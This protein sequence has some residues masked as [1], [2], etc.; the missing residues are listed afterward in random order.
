MQISSNKIRVDIGCFVTS[1]KVMSTQQKHAQSRS[2]LNG[3]SYLGP[4][5]D[6][7]WHILTYFRNRGKSPEAIVF[8][9]EITFILTRHTFEDSD[10]LHSRFRLCD[11]ADRKNL[12]IIRKTS[13][14]CGYQLK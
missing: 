11:D 9:Q 1:A 3:P 8:L 4:F 6:L 2:F 13:F 5:F 12:L 10:T 7:F 14:V